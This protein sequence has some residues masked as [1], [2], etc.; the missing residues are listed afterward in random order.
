MQE[1]ILENLVKW[2]SNLDFSLSKQ[3][4]KLSFTC[5][6]LN[7]EVKNLPREEFITEV[8]EKGIDGV[9]KLFNLKVLGINLRELFGIKKEEPKQKP[10]KPEMKPEKPSAKQEVNEDWIREELEKAFRNGEM[11]RKRSTIDDL[12]RDWQRQRQDF[13]DYRL[14]FKDV[15]KFPWNQVICFVE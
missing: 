7:I 13:P 1:I 5:K 14:D 2:F 3:N 10:E 15:P 12:Y 8:T 11:N 4:D 6:E 9:E